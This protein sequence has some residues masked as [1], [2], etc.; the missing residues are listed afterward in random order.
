M[1]LFIII[2]S[3]AFLSFS[4]ADKVYV[5]MSESSVAYHLT[6]NCTG[7]DNCTHEIKA[8]TV[9]EAVDLKKRECKKC[10]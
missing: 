7:L 2:L 6:K 4:T 10:Y 1:K 3:Y 9:S 5:C 8:M